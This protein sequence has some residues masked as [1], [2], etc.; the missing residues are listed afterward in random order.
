MLTTLARRSRGSA[1]PGYRSP[2][3]VAIYVEAS[4]LSKLSGYETTIERQTYRA[5]HE[6]ER[7]QAARRADGNAPPPV[8][9]DVDISRDSRDEH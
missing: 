4:V 7:R 1:A 2:Q 5:Q 8:S 9:I 3:E 6:L